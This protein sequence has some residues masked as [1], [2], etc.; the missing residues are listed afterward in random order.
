MNARQRERLARAD[1]ELRFDALTRQLYATDAS[2]YQVE[3]AAVAFPRSPHQ[4]QSLFQA[5]SETS[6]AIIPRGAGTGLAGGCVGEGM[7]VELARYNRRISN[8]DLERGTVRVDPGVVLDQLNDYLHPHGLCFGPD[9]ATSS[10]ATLGGMISNNSS[11]ARVP[12]YGTT[13]DHVH[14]LDIVL[15]DGRVET[16]TRNSDSLGPLKKAI[17]DIIAVRKAE[18]EQRMPSGLLKRRPGYA[19]DRWL[20]QGPDLVQILA[21]SEGTLAAIVSA[22]LKLAPLPAQK[23]VAVLFFGSV[24][25]AMQATVSLLDLKPAAIEHIDRALFDQ[26]RGQLAF[27]PVRDLLRLDAEPCESILIVEFYD[28][29]TDRL[30]AT[31]A[32]NLGLRHYLT[33][34]TAEMNLIWALRKA[35]LSLLTGC[36][37]PAKPTP[38]IEDTAVRPE[39]LPEYVNGVRKIMA[40]LGLHG[41]FYG[42]A[43]AGLLHIRPVVDLHRA[44][45]I[46]RYRKMAEEV[47]VFLKQFQGSIA[48]EHGVGIA[49]TEFLP[50]HLGPELTEAL[51]EIKALF[52]P[53]NLMNP[54]KIISDGRY[55]FDRDLR[56]GDGYHIDPPFQ[57]VLAFC[58]KDESFVGNLE[59]CNGCGGCRKD[60]PTM[61]PTFVA[62]GD[63]IM[64]TRGRANVIRAVLDQR[65]RGGG[66][67]LSSAALDAALS[68]CISCKACTT[69]CPSNVNMALLKAEL[70]HARH[71]R[72]GLPLR[73]R[74]IANVDFLGEIGCLTPRLTNRLFRARWVRTWMDRALGLTDKR[75][76]PPYASE[77]FDHWFNR[78]PTSRTGTRGRIIL[79]DDTFVRYHEPQVGKAAVTVLEAAG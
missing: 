50:D 33:T 42:H 22:E 74:L 39:Q 24:P 31:T 69:E 78:R 38:G 65:L 9:V 48:A 32:R 6:T 36:K 75:P 61:C 60:A 77:R 19:L 13:V 16:V 53:N 58:S 11:G 21:G 28:E 56:W 49:R 15:P 79:W 57:P 63:E 34:D 3:P 25:D 35:G 26:T 2:V 30:N 72:E 73:D 40:D 52:D 45:D 18:I 20:R 47:S 62:T 54:G 41:S 68:N 66:D 14:S 27:R 64:S 4:V 46:R 1:C 76:L 70:L 43:A 8:L 29:V 12:V 37:G 17:E 7:V 5:A 67:P 55:R 10:R 59:Q 44:D 51:R 71:A 23:G